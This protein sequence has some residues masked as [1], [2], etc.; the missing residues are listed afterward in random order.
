LIVA[1]GRSTKL[2]RYAAHIIRYAYGS[3]AAAVLAMANALSAKRP[4]LPESVQ[5]LLRSP[6]LQAAAKAF[7]EAENAV[8][9]FGSDGT[10]LESSQALV[11]ACANLLI[12]TGHT[13]RANNGL[14][15]VWQRANDQGAWDL[16]FQP[17]PDLEGAMR[18]AKALYVV[19]ADPA[20]DDPALAQTGDFLVVQDLFLTATAKLADVVLPVQSFI[21]RQGSFTSGERR[22][23]RYYPAVP[24][25]PGSK[26]D[27]TVAAEIGKLVGVELESRAVANVLLRIAESVPD[28]AGLSYLKL[29]EVTEQW[30]IMDRD[31]LFYGGTG[32]ENSQGMGVRLAPA[33]QRGEAIPLTWPQLAEVSLPEN[34]LLLVPVTRLYDRGQTVM[35]SKLLHGRIPQPYVALNPNEAS[36]LNLGQNETAE[37]ILKGTASFVQLR[38]DEGVPDGVALVPRSLGVPISRP[39]TGELRAV[40]KVAT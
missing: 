37:L 18:S 31:D 39:S 25:R 19:A 32:Y 17:L 36:R 12:S 15:G 26:A 28:Y 11:Q 6:E 3:E 35:P 34:G 27:F 9:L 4:D 1:N 22:V 2:E 16:G 13:G 8:I 7:A 30:P 5:S 21:E 14:I 20:G 40:E 24:E 29:A 33:A 38:L 23:Q 10:G